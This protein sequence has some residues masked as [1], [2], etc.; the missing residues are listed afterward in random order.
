MVCAICFRCARPSLA[1]LDHLRTIGDHFS[2]FRA[3]RPDGNCFYRAYLFGTLEA[4]VK[5]DDCMDSLSE[6]RT[7]FKALAAFCEASGYDSFAVNDFHELLDEQLE[8]L[9][10]ACSVE[11]LES[12]VFADAS[13]DGY[14]IAFMRC[15]C[16]AYLR[17][18][19]DQYAGFLPEEYASVDA[20]IRGEVDPMYKDCDQLQIVALS[21]ALEV[22]L[23]IVYLDQSVGEPAIHR[24]GP[25][26]GTPV[27]VLY[28]PGH[29]DL[30]Y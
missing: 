7:K 27:V 10:S 25:E 18:N 9:A 2:G 21:K 19:A 8:L 12:S 16:G 28:R 14:M 4:A 1:F 24:F 6:L 29:Y 11:T 5:S 20:F 3:V 15:C 26:E 22:P 17:A 23:R 30:L 13:V